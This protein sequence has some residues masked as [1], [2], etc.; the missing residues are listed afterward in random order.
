MFGKFTEKARRVIF[1]ARYEVSRLGASEVRTEHLLLG[2]LRERKDLLIRFLPAHVTAEELRRQIEA[3][4]LAGP[5]IPTS[6]EVPLSGE[7]K[8]V[9]LYA[10]EESENLSD[11]YVRVEHLLLGLL[12]REG[13]LAKQVLTEN[14]VALSQVR[15]TLRGE[16]EE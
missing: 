15:Q 14:G 10:A 5:K 11:K 4:V 9:L 3:R 13:S 2:L 8:E 12:R 6:V 16:A 1:F 7:V